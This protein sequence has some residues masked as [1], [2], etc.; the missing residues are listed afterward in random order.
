[1]THRWLVANNA[2][3]GAPPHLSGNYRLGHACDTFELTFVSVNLVPA[4]HQMHGGTM[5][6]GI[7]IRC[8]TAIS[9]ANYQ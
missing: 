4:T 1:M 5:Q 8:L 2:M 9:V 3:A 6:Y 7:R